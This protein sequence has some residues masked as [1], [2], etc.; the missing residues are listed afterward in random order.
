V[1]LAL[2]EGVVTVNKIES[3][4]RIGGGEVDRQQMLT[5][6]Q[7]ELVN[8]YYYNGINYYMFIIN[9]QNIPLL[10]SP[11]TRGS[12]SVIHFINSD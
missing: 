12:R 7:R 5:A 1:V 9:Y 6:K 4:L 11:D 2:E 3:Q 8:K 10:L